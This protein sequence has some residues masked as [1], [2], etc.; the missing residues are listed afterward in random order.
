MLKPSEP[1]KS[2]NGLTPEI[3]KSLENIGIEYII[4]LIAMTC[5]QLLCIKGIGIDELNIV[6]AALRCERYNLSANPVRMCVDK[7]TG[8]TTFSTGIDVECFPEEVTNE[9]SSKVP[10]EVTI[11][12]R[13]NIDT[14]RVEIA[15][16][17]GTAMVN[18]RPTNALGL[19][20]MIAKKARMLMN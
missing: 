6:S 19:S 3:L 14:G 10:G 9:K 16:P 5:S 1:I 2:L 7:D 4:Q 13:A 15:F 17:P 8:I 11:G 18:F 20:K 12:V